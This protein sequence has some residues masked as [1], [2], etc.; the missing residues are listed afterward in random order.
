MRQEWGAQEPSIEEVQ[1]RL[2]RRRPT[3]WDARRLIAHRLNQWI[4]VEIL[5]G[6]F[7]GVVCEGLLR[8]IAHHPDTGF[9]LVFDRLRPTASPA[10]LPDVGRCRV[11][12]RLVRRAPEFLAFLA[13]PPSRWPWPSAFLSCPACGL[14]T[15]TGR[16]CQ[17]C[18]TLVRKTGGWVGAGFVE[19]Q[20]MLR[21]QDACCPCNCGAVLATGWRFCTKCGH[22]RM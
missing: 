7:L 18:G 1:G 22:A 2:E 5:D 3:I 21:E 20:R 13:L 19:A 8:D 9:V 15:V 10:R 12:L 4:A 6:Q 16:F 11:P 17:R 14:T